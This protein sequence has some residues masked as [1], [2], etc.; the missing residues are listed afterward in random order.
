MSVEI[1]YVR[2][3]DLLEDTAPVRLARRLGLSRRRQLSGLGIAV[4]ALPLLTLLLDKFDDRLSLDGQV[5]LYLLVVVVVAVVGGAVASL[6]SAVAAAL[7][8]NYFFV[9]PLHTL[10]VADPD[11]AV[12]LIVFVVVASL[13]SGA[14]EIAVRRAQTAARARAEAETLSALTGPDLTGAE[15][16]HD[17]LRYAMKTFRMESVALKVREPGSSEWIDADRFGWAHSEE[18]APVRFDLPAG[19]RLRLIGRGPALF[20]EDEHVLEAFA[21]A[22]RTAYEGQRL[23][24]EAEEARTLATVDKQRTA[25][26]AAVGHDLRTPLAGIKASV[27][28]LRQTDVEWSVEEREE[29]LATI[30]DST[31]R[32]ETV[33]RNLLDASR[34]QAGSLAVRTEAVALDEIA[35]AAALDLPEAAG[36]LELEVPEDLPLVKA[37]PGL[38]QRVFVNVLD[39]AVRHGGGD[40]PITIKAR[41]GADNAK[42]EIVDHGPGV[43]EAAR[44]GLFQP[45]QRT[46][47]HGQ[48]GLG[49]GL[50]V[51]RGFVE[52]MGGAMVADSTPGGGMTM[53]IRLQLAEDGASAALPEEEL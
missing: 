13:V 22:A 51:A 26:L 24:G 28:T 52:A 25:L 41:A 10:N 48:Q 30:E 5:L 18:E 36:Q 42:I 6:I 50:S 29:L 7:L 45:F 4:V 1:T 17:V 3:E 35:S 2:S 32:L 11:Q 33:V 27:S 46:G 47:D 38:L 53:R 44:D 21:A 34:L 12:A 23:S 43:P 39:N 31:D 40:E 15:S 16:L 20:A 37:D 19:P 49:L 14:V 8:I 9:E